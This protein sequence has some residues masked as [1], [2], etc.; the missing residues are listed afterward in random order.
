MHYQRVKKYGDP[1]PVGKLFENDPSPCLVEGCSR[2]SSG[3]SHGWCKLHYQRW[4]R[5]GHPG[6]PDPITVSSYPSGTLC[7]EDGCV[8]SV[9]GLGFC[10]MHYERMKKHGNPGSLDRMTAPKGSGYVC[11]DGYRVVQYGGERWLE[12]RF[13]MEQHLG[14]KLV[15]NETVHHKNGN[16]LDNRLENLELWSTAQPKGQRIDDKVQWAIELLQQ[17]K[18]DALSDSASKA[19]S[20]TLS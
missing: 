14:R 18:P 16:R 10:S 2:T 17:Y 19:L 12:Q 15:D 1:G 13:V 8:R 4:K 20:L 5:N 6:G 7:A 9:Y 3:R 11:R